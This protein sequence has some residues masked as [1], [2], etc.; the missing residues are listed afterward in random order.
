MLATLA[1]TIALSGYPQLANP[2]LQSA[3]TRHLEQTVF[4]H[5]PKA[6]QTRYTRAGSR[7]SPKNGAVIGTVVGGAAIGLSV[8]YL[9]HVLEGPCW[10]DAALWAGMGAGAGALVGAGIDAL[11]LRRVA[12]RVPVRF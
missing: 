10:S 5:A 2:S 11:F 12:I 9:C 8:A 7:D 4:H 6:A 3:I 1:L